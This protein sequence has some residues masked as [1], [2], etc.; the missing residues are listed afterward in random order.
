VLQCVAV[1]C[2]VLQSAVACCSVFSYIY[3]LHMDVHVLGVC[4]CS[5]L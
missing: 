1:C 3:N 5:V 4:V 2:R